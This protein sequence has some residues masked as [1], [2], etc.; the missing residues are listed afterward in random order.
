MKYIDEFDIDLVNQALS[1]NSTEM[2]IQGTCDLFTTKPVGADRKLYKVLGKL[3]NPTEDEADGTV[4][5]TSNGSEPEKKGETA[6][7]CTRQNSSSSIISSRSN[8]S[9]KSMDG[10]NSQFVQLKNRSFSYSYT[11]PIPVSNDQAFKRSHSFASPSPEPEI[12][13]YEAD[14][15]FGPLT[16]SSS[17]KL[18]GYLI[19]A[20]NATFPDHDFSTV[21]PN[22]FHLVPSTAE[23]IAKV[24]SLLISFGKSTGLDWVWQTINTH[25]ELDQCICFQFDPQQSFVDDLGVMWCNM[26]FIYNKKKKRVA[27][28]YFLATVLNE[29][30]NGATSLRRRNSKVG[31]L[32][33][34]GMKLGEDDSEYDLRYNNDGYNTVYEDVFEED[35]DVNMGEEG[36][37]NVQGPKGAFPEFYYEDE[38]DYAM[39]D[40]EMANENQDDEGYV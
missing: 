22:H 6:S 11:K 5:I 28:L 7:K 8:R 17:R 40:D 38:N 36:A 34:E 18:F 2:H 9:S 4:T 13:N 39:S 3:Y 16:Q 10:L 29:N 15:P 30:E 26:Y 21:E 24:N 1:F 14:S 20:L 31:T 19:G 37:D 35:D 12:L 25:I 32:D 27:F 33:E 23:L